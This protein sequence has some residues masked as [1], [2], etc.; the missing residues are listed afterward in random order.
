LVAHAAILTPKGSSH[1]THLAANHVVVLF[2]RECAAEER[3]SVANEISGCGGLVIHH[4]HD[5][6]SIV[7]LGAGVID[8]MPTGS[9]NVFD[10]NAAKHL[11]R[12]VN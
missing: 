5:G 7:W 10:V 11:A 8:Q 12:F 2:L 9:S 4:V 6:W 1:R 3:C